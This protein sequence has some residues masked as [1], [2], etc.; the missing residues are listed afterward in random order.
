MVAWERS[1]IWPQ[2][3]SGRIVAK[4]GGATGAMISDTVNLRL[5]IDGISV[6]GLAAP[7]SPVSTSTSTTLGHTAS[8]SMVGDL[9]EVAIFARALAASEIADLYALA[10]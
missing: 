9:D 2:T 5:Y 1:L 7:G 4:Y 10:Q 8:D 3:T 6:D